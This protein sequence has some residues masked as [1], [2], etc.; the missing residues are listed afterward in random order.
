MFYGPQHFL[1][2]VDIVPDLHEM[3]A[4]ERPR[5]ANDERQRFTRSQFEA[6]RR[7]TNVFAGA[8]RVADIDT[9]DRRADD[10]GTLVTGN[11]F[12]VVGVKP[13]MGRALTPADESG[14]RRQP[15][16]VLSFAAGSGV[17]GRTP[18]LGRRVLVNG[19]PHEVVGVMPEGFVD[20]P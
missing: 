8:S 15:V 9:P 16:I 18:R 20:W 1:F 14:L 17:F 3:F 11:I 13:S 19:A 7:E 12:Q 6:L 5:D 10:A 4:V 2:R